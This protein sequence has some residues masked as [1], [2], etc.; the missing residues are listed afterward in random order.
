M[1]GED[2]AEPKN[3]IVRSQIDRKLNQQARQII[4]L[5]KQ[6]IQYKDKRIELLLFQNAHKEANGVNKESL[7]LRGTTKGTCSLN[8]FEVVRSK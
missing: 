8:L 4:V 2:I 5:E 7:Q 6:T 1:D 3:V